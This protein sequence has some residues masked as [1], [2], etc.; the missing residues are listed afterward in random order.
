MMRSQNNNEGVTRMKILI[1]CEEHRQYEDLT[2]VI[3][4]SCVGLTTVSHIQWTPTYDEFRRDLVK[5]AY[6][7]V[8]VAEKG[9]MGMEICISTRKVRPNIPLFWFSDDPV[10]ATQSYRLNCTYFGSLPVSV[11]VM[12]NAFRRIRETSAE[13]RIWG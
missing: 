6:D 11:Q 7:L 10:F 4:G 8:I 9:A 12:A 2:C 1:F 3:H 5:Q 13:Q